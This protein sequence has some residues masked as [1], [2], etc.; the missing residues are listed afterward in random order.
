MKYKP[1]VSLVGQTISRLT[2]VLIN[3]EVFAIGHNHLQIRHTASCG[4]TIIL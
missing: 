1:Y 3:R 2:P 4:D